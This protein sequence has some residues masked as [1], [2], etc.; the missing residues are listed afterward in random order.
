MTRSAALI[1]AA[2]AGVIDAISHSE[3]FHKH[4]IGISGKFSYYTYNCST[5]KWYFTPIFSRWYHM[6]ILPKN[7]GIHP[8]NDPGHGWT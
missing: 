2:L 6:E 4:S 8:N 5:L 7:D 1:A 3:N